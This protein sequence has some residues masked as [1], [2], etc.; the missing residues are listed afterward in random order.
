MNIGQ[1]HALRKAT[2]IDHDEATRS[3]VRAVDE[4]TPWLAEQSARIDAERRIPDDVIER[5]IDTGIFRL[6]Q[7]RQFGG[8]GALPSIIWE[9][10]YKVACGSPSC[11][12]ITGL[13]AAN[14]LAM[15]RFS[16]E[17][18]ADIFMGG[19][20]AVFSLLSGGVGANIVT[21]RHDDHVSVSGDWRYASGIDVS[22]WVGTLI[23]LPPEEGD[24]PPQPHM[25]LIPTA[26]FEI[27]H[28]SWH[29]IGMRG[30]GSK[31]V[32][33]SDC[34][35]PYHRIMD[36]AELQADRCHPDCPNDEVAQRFP[37]NTLLAM[38]VIAP[39]LGTAQASAEAVA[40]IVLDR[41]NSGTKKRQ[42]E[43]NVTHVRVATAI[44][45]IKMLQRFVIA[46]TEALERHLREE[47]AVSLAERARI[48]TQFAVAARDALSTCQD[49]FALIG[50][51]LLPEG[52]RL[53]GLFRD[54][55]TMS[56]HFLLQPDIIGEAYGRLL[57]GL[58][59]KPGTRI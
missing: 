56:T 28:D 29:V 12:W 10:T 34:K 6:A 17:A 21:Q 52:T 58:E 44:A 5:L 36:W 57:L 23:E 37:F 8:L 19:K 27:D 31:N 30:T 41:V 40:G 16:P 55:H 48:R 15:A 54:M 13:G 18:Q 59:L 47:N 50:G 11:A 3:V 7:P 53:E 43:D 25:A 2:E 20:P 24:G 33:L 46:E 26:D 51:S 35:V 42:I 14:A 49:L 39:T 1:R 4:L 9:T 38:S 45:R 32:T 22:N